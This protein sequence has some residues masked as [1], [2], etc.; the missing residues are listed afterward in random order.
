MVQDALAREKKGE[1]LSAMPLW[2]QAVAM[3]EPSG[4]AH[5]KL[6]L[7]HRSGWNVSYSKTTGQTLLEQSVAKAS[8]QRCPFGLC[9]SDRS[10]DAN[11][12]GFATLQNLAAAGPVL[13]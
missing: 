9:D 13:A 7:R 10:A 8:P 5:W 4:L 11:R 12:K 1:W 6:S 2:Q 3:D